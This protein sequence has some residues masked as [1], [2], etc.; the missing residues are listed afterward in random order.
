MR[1]LSFSRR[2]ETDILNS[3]AGRLSRK[4]LGLAVLRKALVDD[5]CNQGREKRRGR[6]NDADFE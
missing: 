5:C 6:S 1:L 4:D 3:D 2:T